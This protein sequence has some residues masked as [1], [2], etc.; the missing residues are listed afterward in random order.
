[1]IYASLQSL[2]AEY[3]YVHMHTLMVTL[4][5]ATCTCTGNSHRP[6][7]L[8]LSGIVGANLVWSSSHIQ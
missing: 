3:M 2:S 5:Q 8:I 1:M 7:S 6:P 4:P